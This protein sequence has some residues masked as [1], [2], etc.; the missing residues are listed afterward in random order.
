MPTLRPAR[1]EDSDF[2]YRVKKEALGEYI[3]QTWGWDE[4][5]QRT[6][7]VKDFN[8]A[9][10]WIISSFDQD[11]GWLEAICESGEMRIAGIYLLP[12]HQN[13]GVGTAVIKDV[14]GEAV[15]RRLPVTLQVLKVNHRAKAL[16]ERLG[17][18]VEGET[19]THRLMRRLP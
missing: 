9:T 11:V 8:P 1:P 5:L 12:E 15:K 18:I 16:Y 7:H 14:L 6:L 17:F 2:V 19:A 4:E 3:R 13:R 10:V